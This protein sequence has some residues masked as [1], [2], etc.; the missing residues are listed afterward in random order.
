MAAGGEDHAS[1]ADYR[2]VTQNVDGFANSIKFA[3]VLR[4]ERTDIAMLQEINVASKDRGVL[5]QAFGRNGMQ[6]WLG[7]PCLLYTSPSPRDR[8]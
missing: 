6:L 1:L 2:V 5:K 7:R 3:S 4:Q 8:G